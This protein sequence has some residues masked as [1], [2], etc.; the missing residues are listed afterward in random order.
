MKV[1]Q[2]GWFSVFFDKRT[3]FVVSR[4]GGFFLACCLIFLADAALA[5]EMRQP[6]THGTNKVLLIGLIPEQNIF[7]Q[8]ERYTPLSEYLYYKTGWKIELKVLTRYGNIVDNFVST[9]MDGAFFGSFTYALAHK[10]TGVEVVA[11]PESVTG[12]STY[13]GLIFVRKDGKIKNIG[14]MKGKRFA[15][16]DKAT[17][18]GFLLPLVYFKEHGINNYKAYFRETYFT[19]THEDAV[20][21]VLNKKA[22]VGAAK[23]TVFE[24]M[25]GADGRIGK[26]LMIL[27]TSPE[28]PENGLALRK[29][30]D[31]AVRA[32]LA[33]ALLTMHNHPD[34]KIIL[35]HFG[36][37][38][39]IPTGNKDYEPVF[40]YAFKIGLD[41]TR[42]DYM[43]D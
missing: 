3:W 35:D 23:N 11:R 17:T 33:E 28:V 8:I 42:Y 39:F 5:A 6:N 21:D 12:S 13:H 24:R 30:L 36:A 22:D 41:L 34:G 26:E 9:G 4:L 19:G 15:F 1:M 29:S 43:N 10:R 38:R 31:P 18:A 37:R 16:V 32:S 14:D 25:A 2:G 7:K 27:K 40:Q 20:L